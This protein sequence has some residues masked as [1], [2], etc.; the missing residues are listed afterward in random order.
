M[1]G[2]RSTP[3]DAGDLFESCHD[4]STDQLDA[5]LLLDRL[6]LRGPVGTL[7]SIELAYLPSPDA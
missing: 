2:S 4:L 7:L 6:H 3:V 5:G 1:D